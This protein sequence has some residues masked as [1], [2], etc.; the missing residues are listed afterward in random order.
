[1]ILLVAFMAA[2]GLVVR[3]RKQSKTIS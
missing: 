1:L 2:L 3:Y